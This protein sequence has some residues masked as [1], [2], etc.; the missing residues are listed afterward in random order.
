M[1]NNCYLCAPLS[2]S[3]NGIFDQKQGFSH[4]FTLCSVINQPM[5]I[6]SQLPISLAHGRYITQMP[7]SMYTE[8]G[9]MP[10]HTGS[11]VHCAHYS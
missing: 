4:K 5:S 3:L 6:A 2:E 11:S 1:Q 8:S 9:R 10:H 7:E